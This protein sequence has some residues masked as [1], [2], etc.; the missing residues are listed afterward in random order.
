MQ[1]TIRD[2]GLPGETLYTNLETSYAIECAGFASEDLLIGVLVTFD[3]AKCKDGKAWS[4]RGSENVNNFFK[5][6]KD[7]NDSKE[8]VGITTTGRAMNL[9]LDLPLDSLGRQY[10]PKYDTYKVSR[11]GI[12]PPNVNLRMGKENGVLVRTVMD[13]SVNIEAGSKVFLDPANPGFVLNAGTIEIPGLTF[14]GANASNGIV[15]I[16]VMISKY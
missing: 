4:P 1:K 10:I 11:K 15:A 9:G 2:Y 16:N 8:F 13:N 12:L 3:K 14:S 7:G 5:L 6:I